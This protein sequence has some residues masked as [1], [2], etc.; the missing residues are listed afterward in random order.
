MTSSAQL[1]I[2]QGKIE[3]DVSPNQRVADGVFIHNTS[4]QPVEVRVYWEDFAYVAP[5]DG[6]KIFSPAGTGDYSM[7]EWISFSPQVFRLPP[8]AKRKVAYSIDVPATMNR[9]FYGTLFFERTVADSTADTALNIITRVGTLFFIEPQQ[10]QKNIR[11]ENLSIENG[12]L[13]AELVNDSNVITIPEGIYYIMSEEGLVVDRSE[14]DKVY[15]PPG[16]R[17]A[18]GFALKSD[19]ANGNYQMVLTVDLA[20]GDVLVKEVDFTKM[21]SNQI[22]ITN[23]KD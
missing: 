18:Y 23:I 1:F 21:S 9:G 12:V 17:S 4:D 20:D 22:R 19:M 16:A 2:E 3:L 5:Y 13:N 14:I 6:K 8:Y 11:L 10:K 7:S 15:L